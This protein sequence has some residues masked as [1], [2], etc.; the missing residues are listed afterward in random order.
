MLVKYRSDPS[1]T[2]AD[3]F[4]AQ[5]DNMG[6]WRLGMVIA[7]EKVIVASKP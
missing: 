5:D 2:K 3:A 6:G 7:V 4:F 1:T